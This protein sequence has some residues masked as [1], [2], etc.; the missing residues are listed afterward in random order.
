[1]FLKDY[2]DNN[3]HN[4]F[5]ANDELNQTFEFKNMIDFNS[6]GG[7][8]KNQGADV[9]SKIGNFV[10]STANNIGDY[11][12][13]L[14]IGDFFDTFT[15]K[16]NNVEEVKLNDRHNGINFILKLRCRYQ[17]IEFAKSSYL[18]GQSNCYSKK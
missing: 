13:S 14:N 12:S 18:Q 8:K 5:Q 16:N 3:Q 6:M 11:F 7:N 2:E 1:M 15:N 9:G 10:K 17:N 4:P